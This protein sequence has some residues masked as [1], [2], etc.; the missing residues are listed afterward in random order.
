MIHELEAWMTTGKNYEIGLRLLEALHVSGNIDSLTLNLCRQGR[1]AFTTDKM[2]NAIAEVIQRHTVDGEVIHAK[3]AFPA[4]AQADPI[5]IAGPVPDTIPEGLPDDIVEYDRKNR[6]MYAQNK[7]Y[8]GELFAMLYNENGSPLSPRQCAR[9]KDRIF[10]TAA[11]VVS[12]QLQIISNWSRYDYYVKNGVRYP[13]THPEEEKRTVVIWLRDQTKMVE[14]LRQA[15]VHKRKKGSYLN[16]ELVNRYR[17][18]L[19]KI[20]QYIINNL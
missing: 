17:E 2:H 11:A 19:A 5:P 15:E 18:E 7:V 14:Y 10:T 8:R 12:N 4:T 13:G 6:Q 16:P 3:T 20:E 9:N 1:N